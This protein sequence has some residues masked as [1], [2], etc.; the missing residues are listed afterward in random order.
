MEWPGQKIFNGQKLPIKKFSYTT[1]LLR[2]LSK[3]QGFQQGKEKK[4]CTLGSQ[5]IP[6]I[7]GTRMSRLSLI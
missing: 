2:I 4:S 5:M 3:Y 1:K 7:S 6:K